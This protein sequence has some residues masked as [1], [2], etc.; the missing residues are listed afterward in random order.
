MCESS[1]SIKNADG[2]STH[3]HTLMIHSMFK[4]KMNEECENESI[5]FGNIFTRIGILV[6]VIEPF[7]FI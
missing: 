1:H 4:N 7:N 3:T 6:T 2:K 5:N